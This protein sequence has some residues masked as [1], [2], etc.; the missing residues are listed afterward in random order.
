MFGLK[1]CTEEDFYQF[2]YSKSHYHSSDTDG[3]LFGALL[4]IIVFLGIG[5]FY[6]SNTHIELSSLISMGIKLFII[7][8]ILIFMLNRANNKKYAFKFQK[9]ML[10]VVAIN[11]FILGLVI[12]PMPLS[13]A[14]YKNNNILIEII[15]YTI[16]TVFIYLI[17]IFMRLILLIRKGEMRKGCIGLYERLIGRK[18]AYLGFSVPIIVVASK[19]ARRT[20]IEMNNNGFDMGPVILMIIFAF[21]M[22]IA[23]FTIIPECIILAYCKSRFKSFNCSYELYTAKGKKRKRL[24]KQAERE[25]LKKNEQNQNQNQNQKKRKK[26][27]KI[28]TYKNGVE[29]EKRIKRNSLIYHNVLSIKVTCK[30]NEWA[31]YAREL[32]NSIIKNGLHP[33]GPVI[34]TVEKIYK[35]DNTAKIRIY[36]PVNEGSDLE[37]NDKYI[38]IKELK[39]EDGFTLRHA[40]SDD[41]IETATYDTL[42]ET[43][44]NYNLKLV[45][46][47]Y[48]ISLDVFGDGVIDVYAP[49]EKNS[50]ETFL[51][52]G[53]AS[54][55]NL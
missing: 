39:F 36:I 48:N 9:T 6:I 12:Y 20:T 24:I 50:E 1:K 49:I 7:I 27:I 10:I 14:Y 3:K 54:I 8:D 38:F 47:F 15:T 16:I 13:I 17:I 28:K 30:I 32:R 51:K 4:G 52:V 22:Q 25:S 19:S 45:E 46:P 23:M 44:R 26:Y 41:D 42:R 33:T 37:T 35:E 18:I 43:A 29:V 31:I 2:V 55:N 21:I 34:Y 5:S 40:D 53:V 11:W